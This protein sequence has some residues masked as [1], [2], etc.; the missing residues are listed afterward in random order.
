LQ[1]IRFSPHP[2]H[3]FEAKA[4]GNPVAFSFYAKLRFGPP[5]RPLQNRANDAKTSLFVVGE[6]NLL[7][8]K[9][10][11]SYSDTAGA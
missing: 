9:E 10:H 7:I 11:D 1:G 8:V 5:S 4:A 6:R 3:S 2:R